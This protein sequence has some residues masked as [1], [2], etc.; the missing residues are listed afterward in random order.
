M[1]ASR[2]MEASKAVVCYVRFT[3]APAVRC[4][5]TAVIRRQRGAWVKGPKTV[6]HPHQVGLGELLSY[7]FDQASTRL[8]AK[9][10]GPIGLTRDGAVA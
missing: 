9:V 10:G 8:R 1:S 5:Q 3:S 7:G 2:A 6:N 4:A